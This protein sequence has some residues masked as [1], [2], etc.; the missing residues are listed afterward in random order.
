MKSCWPLHH[1]ARGGRPPSAGVC[2][3]CTVLLSGKRPAR[4]YLQ[5]AQFNS[6]R[7]FSKANS[8]VPLS[9]HHVFLVPELQRAQ[10]V[11]SPQQLQGH[12]QTDGQRWG[13]QWVLRLMWCG[14]HAADSNMSLNVTMGTPEIQYL[15]KEEREI[16]LEL[17][18][19]CSAHKTWVRSIYRLQLGKSDRTL[20]AEPHQNLPQ[21]C[22]SEVALGIEEVGKEKQQVELCCHVLL[23][24]D[25]KSSPETETE[26]ALIG[27]LGWHVRSMYEVSRLRFPTALSKSL[28]SY[29]QKGIAGLSLSVLPW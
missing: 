29:L 13:T 16:G 11:P 21:S 23:P 25:E 12:L 14:S 1:V 24:L 3:T 27:A 20:Y 28:V 19:L 4:L 9:Q 26:P 5:L 8:S 18:V 17:C 22:E 15:P 6:C 7:E 10:A 2:N